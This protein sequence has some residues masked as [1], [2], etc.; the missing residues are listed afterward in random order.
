MRYPGN[1]TGMTTKR[2]TDFTALTGHGLRRPQ[3]FQA[4]ALANGW[5]LWAVS[6]M[7]YVEYRR[8][9]R[10]VR[11]GYSCTGAPVEVSWTARG[12]SRATRT[13][14]VAAATA[15]LTAA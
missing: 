5:A 9:S 1:V 8:G 13:G 15:A 4:L 3:E 14:T 2:V 7:S 6:Q 12:W 11:I 10:V